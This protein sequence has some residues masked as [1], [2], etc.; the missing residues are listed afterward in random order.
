MQNNYSMN[1]CHLFA[2]WMHFVCSKL[3]K[4]MSSWVLYVNKHVT[5]EYRAYFVLMQ[6]FRIEFSLKSVY[7]QSI[8]IV[9]NNYFLIMRSMS[10]TPTRRQTKDRKSKRDWEKNAFPHSKIANAVLVELRFLAYLTHLYF[11][12]NQ[13]NK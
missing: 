10:I 5:H 6:T 3:R 13:W 2:M 8:E 11:H 9:T 7:S 1:W 4:I 12:F